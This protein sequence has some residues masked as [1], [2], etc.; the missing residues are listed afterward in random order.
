MTP[1]AL[2]CSPS[3]QS[4]ARASWPFLSSSA[5]VLATSRS[6][7]LLTGQVELAVSPA[8]ESLVLG[9]RLGDYQVWV[10]QSLYSSAALA[11][12]RGRPEAGANLVGAADALCND[13]GLAF[14]P[15]QVTD[16]DELKGEVRRE[17]GEERYE[18]LVA[19]GR[20][21]TLKQAVD[22]A[23]EAVPEAHAGEDRIG[24]SD[25]AT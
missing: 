18:V 10:H 20:R 22:L 11:A 7:Y 24:L 2:Y 17:L 19:E 25:F 23:L 3:R 14:T 16:V 21:L 15:A 12:R 8:R 6:R 4:S 5:G 9:E 1:R 13:H